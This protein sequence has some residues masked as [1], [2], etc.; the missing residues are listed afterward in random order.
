M[1]GYFTCILSAF[2]VLRRFM[3]ERLQKILSKAGV[4][5]RREAEK[6]ILEG[7]VAVNDIIVTELG[8]KADADIDRIVLD[9]KILT[10]QR[11]RL[12][13]MLYKPVGYVTTMKDP[14]GRPIVSDLLKDI[15]TR[16]YPVGRLDYNTEGLLLL[17]NDGEWANRLAHPRHEVD[18][19][20]HVRIR[21]SVA[22]AQIKRLTEGVELEDGLTA[23]AAV[24]VLKSSDNNTW[25]S[26]TIHEGRY[27]Q[28]RRMCEAVSLS[29]VRLKRTRYGMLD[30]GVLKPGEY[31]LLKT[32]E[33]AGLTQ[34]EKTPSPNEN[35]IKRTKSTSSKMQPRNK[36]GLQ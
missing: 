32:A 3:L 12:Y 26:I 21:G 13:V 7:R 24:K 22:P 15:S 28:V 34:G 9:G 27:R 8:S 29:V 20:Y 16:V 14:E 31:R 33:I 1:R 11:D 4:A 5:S 36:K 2:R 10:F 19:E 35:P 25:I 6:I 30:L 18:K 17:T 23:P